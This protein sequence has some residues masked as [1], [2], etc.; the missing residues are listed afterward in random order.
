M[1]IEA[2]LAAFKD[3][4]I[5][6]DEAAQQIRSHFFT[7]LGHTVLDTDR[8]RRTGAAE[9][10]FGEGKSPQQI[11]DIISSMRQFGA[12]VLVT[13]LA[14]DSYRQLT[15][16]PT[17]VQYH[18]TSRLLW[19]QI[20]PPA[21]ASGT[22]AVVSA[23]T[24]DMHVA[25]EAA[26]TAEFYGNPVERIYDVGVAGLHRLLARLDDLRAAKVL[27]VVAGMEGALPSVVGG[28]VDKPIIAVP[29]SVGYGAALDGVAALL[30]M[31]TS[32]ASGVSVVNIDNGFGAGFLANR[33]NRL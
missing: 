29:T 1:N 21:P 26:L 2:V 19:W 15:N 3:G 30:G 28:L 32:C 27:I 10:V 23:G 5:T 24:S 14:Q 17:D 18:A 6:G 20:A 7:D 11:S 8:A 9:V 25:E 16:L 33:I 31:M 4:D 12:N 13:R 22:V